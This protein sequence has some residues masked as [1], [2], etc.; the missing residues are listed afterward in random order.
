M[1][2]SY[3]KQEFFLETAEKAATNHQFYIV[4]DTY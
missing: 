4:H 3:Q 1:F 2:P